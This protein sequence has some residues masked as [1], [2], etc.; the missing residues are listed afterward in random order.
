MSTDDF[1]LRNNARTANLQSD[2][3][4]NRA[5]SSRPVQGAA[6]SPVNPAAAAAKRV[7]GLQKPPELERSNSNSSFNFS[8]PRGSRPNSPPPQ[9]INSPQR[10][11]AG[12]NA[13]QEQ[14]RPVSK[15]ITSAEAEQV[16]HDVIQ[17][18]QQPVKKK[19]KRL[20]KQVAQGSHLQSGTLAARPVVTP[21]EPGPVSREDIAVETQATTPGTKTARLTGQATHFP[22]SPSSST[23]SPV[24]SDSDPATERVKDRRAQRAAGVLLKQPSIVQE[25]WEGEREEE[26]STPVLPKSAARPSSPT[27]A[28]V[29]KRTSAPANS[30]RKIEEPP[31]VL[32][33]DNQMSTAESENRSLAAP[34]MSSAVRGP[35]LSPSRSTRFSN[36]LSSDITQGRKHDPPPRSVSPGKPAL[37]H[38]SPSPQPLVDSTRRQRDSSLSPSEATDVSVEGVSKRKKNA[39]VSFNNEPAIVGVAAEPEIL[40]SPVVSSPQHRESGK[41]WFGLK[42]RNAPLHSPVNEDDEDEAMKPRPQLPTFG[43]V[44]KGRNEASPTSAQ[45]V[46][47]PSSH[48]FTSSVSSSSSGSSRTDPP[49]LDTSVSSDHAIGVMLSHEALQKPPHDPFI[50]LPPDVTSVEGTGMV[51][52]TESHYSGDDGPPDSPIVSARVPPIRVDEA[53]RAPIPPAINVQPSTPGHDETDEPKDQWL[54]EVPGGFPG[55]EGGA[56]TDEKATKS[57]NAPIKSDASGLSQDALGSPRLE[58]TYQQEGPYDDDDAEAATDN[59]S[60]YSDAAEDLSDLEGDGFGSI[61]AIINSP[62]PESPTVPLSSP[63]TS[64]LPAGTEQR[65]EPSDVERNASWDDTQVK[66]SNLALQ[67]KQTSLQPAAPITEKGTRPAGEKKK[68]KKKN[69]IK[70]IDDSAQVN[71]APSLESPLRVPNQSSSYPTIGTTQPRTAN[72]PHIRR[73]M[74]QDQDAVNT[75]TLRSTVRTNTDVPEQKQF[76]NSMRNSPAASAAAASARPQPAQAQYPQSKGTLQKKSLRAAPQNLPP[77]N[78]DSDSESSF[79]RRRRNRST[80]SGQYSMRRSMRT[81]A[82]E[83][84][85]QAPSPDARR[86]VRSLSPTARRPFSSGGGQATLRTSMRVPVEETPPS[87]KRSSS[88]FNRSRKAKSPVRPFSSIIGSSQARPRVDSLDEDAAPM[89]SSFQSRYADSSDDEGGDLHLRPVRGIPRKH[90]EGDST[91]LEDSS[92]D[93]AKKTKT[94]GL[95]IQPP[96]AGSV[97]NEPAS[98]SSPSSKKKRGLFGRFRKDKGEPASPNADNTIMARSEADV[99]IKETP[100]KKGKSTA[101]GFGSKA[102]QEAMIEATRQKLEAA[103][104]RPQSPTPGK[105]QRRVTPQRVMSDSWPLPPKLNTDNDDRPYTSEGINGNVA[106]RPELGERGSTSL[107]ADSATPSSI[108]GRSGK[109]KRFPMLRKAFGLKD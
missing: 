53:Q 102:E 87:A 1:E 20:D 71:E 94:K 70:P 109:K 22:P 27:P 73:S 108:L 60:I 98:P 13:I 103:Q 36:R 104:E 59:D 25:D 3:P 83:E 43:S 67:A 7:T 61:N 99:Q 10:A 79:R 35:S 38:H 39:H 66:W 63:P 77:V 47:F 32:R 88:L 21:L 6:T 86:G 30:S 42:S 58:H 68:K 64:P 81:P 18:A 93:E 49:T 90:D 92:E 69:K 107:T 76:R 62:V 101:L 91:D 89:P 44:R 17:A 37:K 33:P 65:Y 28:G 4:T 15:Q 9:P 75:G 19:K 12:A 31:Q 55:Q 97:P 50:P 5:P 26:A 23:D 105:L 8:Y 41:K 82:V 54:V 96:A 51:S 40:E 74:R 11:A 24:G 56:D 14:K 57:A 100:T 95:R 84:D 85:Y 78:D 34:D 106:T 29:P 16:Q 48:A 2:A 80:Q 45:V 46:P 52:D 72:Q